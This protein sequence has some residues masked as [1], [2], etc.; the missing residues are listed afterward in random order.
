MIGTAGNPLTAKLMA[1]V[2]I[3]PHLLSYLTSMGLS[4][5]RTATLAYSAA[6]VALFVYGLAL[7]MSF[8]LPE[9]KGES[10]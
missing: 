9:P 3:G 2:I 1:P 6:A 4:G 10:N 7:V 5:T 8:L